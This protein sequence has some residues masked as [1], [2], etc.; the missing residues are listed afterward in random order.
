MKRILSAMFLF[1]GTFSI[2]LAQ[3]E[4]YSI[5]GSVF[6]ETSQEA[7]SQAT[8]QLLSYP[9]STYIKG[10]VTNQYGIFDISVKEPNSYIVKISFVGYKPYIRTLKLSKQR[11]SIRLGKIQLKTDAILLKEAVI[12]AEAAPVQ[13]KADTLLY[14]SSAFRV[15]EGSTLQSLVSK[16]PGAEI[17][18]DGTIT[19]NGKEIKKILIDGK[20]FFAGDTKMAM[21]NLPAKMVEKVKMY[22]KSSDLTRI[23][24]IDDG[25]EEAVLD[26]SVKKGM[27]AG[28]LGDI[29]LGAGTEKRYDSRFNLNRFKDNQ[30]FTLLGSANNTSDQSFVGGGHRWRGSNRGLKASKMLGFNFATNTD[31]LD[32]GGS[33]QYR[34]ENE[35]IKSKTASQ[36]FLNNT[37]SYSN[38]RTEQL[39]RSSSVD[40][41]YQLEWRPNDKSN[42]ILRSRFS[43]NKQENLTEKLSGTFN[44]DPFNLTDDPQR[45]LD[46]NNLAQ[47]EDVLKA[48][49]VNAVRSESFNTSKNKDGFIK[50]QANRRLSDKGRNLTLV[51]DFKYSDNDTEDFVNSLTNYLL[52]Q[53]STLLRNQYSTLP[54]KSY[55]Y[56]AKLAYSEPIADRT[57]LQFSYRLA[58]NKKKSS[59]STFDLNQF[60]QN[61]IGEL[62]TDYF[63]YRIDSLERKAD[64]IFYTHDVD[65]TFRKIRKKYQLSVGFNLQPQRSTL[66]YRL[67]AY[68]V[69]TTRTV[70]NFSPTLD[71]RYKFSKMSQLRLMYRTRSSQPSMTNLLPVTDYSNPMNIKKGNP[72][73]KPSY[74]SYLRLFYNTYN[75]ESQRGIM[76]HAYFQT[77]KN[78]ISN[79]VTYD[80]QTGGRITQPE[81]ING[82]WMA[83]SMVNLTTALK[84][85]KKFTFNSFSRVF[86]R[87]QV[88]FS[89]VDEQNAEKNTTKT[90]TLFEKL[91]STYRN[92]WIEASLLGSIEYVHSKNELL[93]SNDL[94]TYTFSYG[95]SMNIT[96]PWGMSLSTDLVNS[97]R[98]G[99]ADE[100]LN[101]DE[102]VW[103]AQLSQ[104]FFKGAPLTLSLQ[105]F[106]ILQNQSNISRSIAALSRTDVEYNAINH[107]AMLHLIY[108]FNLFGSKEMR[109][110]MQNASK[111]YRHGPGYRPK[112]HRSRRF[113][114]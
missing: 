19:V 84:R 44:D 18:E 37:N 25:E 65:V 58:Y 47:A 61:E 60:S 29:D 110:K 108:R 98:R 2:L 109:Q 86:Y 49:R 62:P 103:N 66:S 73:L 71:F 102:W 94:D 3:N 5:K 7:V 52:F 4:K 46:Y 56:R 55:R 14:N 57:Y 80:E 51:A 113:R 107:Y 83:A 106:D 79:R 68:T 69:D 77:V 88:A 78:A 72:G 31:Q 27:K 53:D 23:T 43:Y 17:K 1:M 97:A 45:Y 6:D 105:M 35:D 8:I 81:N 104:T 75:P 96:F 114:R 40:A 16:L 54:T 41:D 20:E 76:T 48:I 100:S 64:Y 15:P 95:T 36:L 24:G 22:D 50:I 38:S 10:M 74:T 67:G 30:Q 32:M 28:Y 91:K 90:T 85:N 92:D 33:V 99:F 70:L 111:R 12:T 34:H 93:P 63:D 11:K 9:D 42:L 39:N 87:N 82:N 101:R 89:S 59:K 112:G 13:V 21:R 26:L